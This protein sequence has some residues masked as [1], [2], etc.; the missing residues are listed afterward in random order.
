[1]KSMRLFATEVL[2]RI[3]HIGDAAASQ[4]EAAATAAS[5]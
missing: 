2:P 5:A 3:R 4:P 1:M